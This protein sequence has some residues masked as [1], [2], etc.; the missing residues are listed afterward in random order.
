MAA[1]LSCYVL[2]FNSERRLDEVLRAVRP[3]ADELIVLDSGSVD[4]TR[5]IAANHG[6]RLLTRPFDNFRDQRLFAQQQCRHRWILE[7]DSD[8]ILSPELAGRLA[9][10]KTQELD[11]DGEGGIDAYK[12]R[13]EW[14]VLGRRV[15]AFYPVRTPDEVI[16]LY[17][18]DRISYHGS[19][20]IHESA[21]GPN[22]RVTR[23]DEPLLHYTCDTVDQLYSK[24][25]LYTRLS[26]LDMAARG[27]RA[28]RLR[29]NVVPWLLWF[30][31]YVLKGGW[32]DGEIG[33]LHARY[34]RDTAY[35]KLVKL[36]HD[37]A[38]ERSR[39]L[40]RNAWDRAGR[41]LAGRR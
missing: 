11:A 37:T 41:M 19:R 29:V 15:H 27:E 21:R 14:F 10:M 12:I 31:W 30:R 33:R 5:A 39:G 34:V 38:P 17:R 4:R 3:V 35:L 22:R 20:I 7:V 18:K 6:A 2:T 16:R 32:R 26:A 36:R 40:A 8:E 9:Q 13:R 24:L 25:N 23:I 1:A 28:G